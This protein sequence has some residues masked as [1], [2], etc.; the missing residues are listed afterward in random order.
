MFVLLEFNRLICGCLVG[1]LVFDLLLMLVLTMPGLLF[2]ML[3]VDLGG[4]V[5]C[6]VWVFICERL[7][8]CLCL[9]VGYFRCLFVL[10][11]VCFRLGVVVF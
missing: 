9:G 11:T 8:Y 3:R 7:F 1:C 10:L 4:F 2:L 6:V 5:N